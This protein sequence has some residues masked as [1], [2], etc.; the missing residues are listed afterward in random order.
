MTDPNAANR[1]NDNA[2]GDRESSR[3]APSSSVLGIFDVLDAA[4]FNRSI[5]Q[6]Q[7]SFNGGRD[8]TQTLLLRH[9]L[10]NSI[11]LDS[12]YR[13]DTSLLLNM[14]PSLGFNQH[15]LSDF[16]LLNLMSSNSNTS[17][18][19][20]LS[21][22]QAA[23]LGGSLPPRLPNFPSGS[24]ELLRYVLTNQSNSLQELSSRLTGISE[25]QNIS[26]S[27][28]ARPAALHSMAGDI[29]ATLL[30][31]QSFSRQANHNT[32][33]SL[34]SPLLGSSTVPCAKSSS[35]QTDSPALMSNEGDRIVPVFTEADK[36]VLSEYQSYLRQQMVFVETE[37]TAKRKGGKVQGR[38]KPITPGQVGVM[39]VHCAKVSFD[40]R[41]RGAVYYPATL[42]GIYQAAQNMSKNHFE[43]R[44]Q[45]IPDE[46]RKQLVHLKKTKSVNVGT[47]KDY[48]KNSAE[49]LGI[50]EVDS[51]LFF[52]KVSPSK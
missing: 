48:W 46:V 28:L 47:G 34:R 45:S 51:R 39:C 11:S 33:I 4:N 12:S 18:H 3:V 17:P 40:S 27:F 36:Y 5:S 43:V 44:C 2:T 42:E 31:A 16:S 20:F 32:D 15:A 13:P 26:T 37:Y 23:Q 35:Q 9:L 10:W 1:N 29:G 50:C 6:A 22:Q 14:P 52:A 25:A 38:N 7:D 30:Q 21:T 49:N 8:L 19:H 41:P 24:D